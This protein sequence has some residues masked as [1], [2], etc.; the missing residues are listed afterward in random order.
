MTGKNIQ[1]E[2]RPVQHPARQRG[3]EV[4]QLGRRQVVVE[5]HHVCLGGS[6][7]A[8]DLFDFAGS[9][10][11][12]RIGSRPMLNQLGNHLPTGACHQLTKLG[13]G[14]IRVQSR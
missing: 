3:I 11:R 1:N 14:F 9:D 8:R 4:A 10:Q 5:Q 12:C 13:Q 6:G 7:H 2:L